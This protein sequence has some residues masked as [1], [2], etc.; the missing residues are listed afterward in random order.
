MFLFYC[1]LA[2]TVYSLMANIQAMLSKPCLTQF[3][4]DNIFL[5]LSFPSLSYIIFYSVLY[6][7]L[8]VQNMSHVEKPVPSGQDKAE[9]SI[10]VN[11]QAAGQPKIQP[12]IAQKYSAGAY[13]QPG[14]TKAKGDEQDRAA[15]PRPVSQH[16][17]GHR[18]R[19]SWLGEQAP[20]SSQIGL[21][22]ARHKQASRDLHL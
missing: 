7:F 4:P 6:V 3:S 1:D 5:S 19:W 9:Q 18:Y 17:Q 20:P 11:T 10:T 21:P 14:L 12:A 13:C 16:L 15:A 22:P 8:P 2:C